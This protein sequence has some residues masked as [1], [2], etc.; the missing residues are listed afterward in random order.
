MPAIVVTSLL[1]AGLHA[2][3]WPAPIGIF[4]LSMALGVVY[5]RTGSLL[6]AMVMHG[7]F[8]G[9]STILFLIGTLARS[10]QEPELGPE[11]VPRLEP[12][13]RAVVDLFSRI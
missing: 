11:V 9:C 8:N 2:P 4:F 5:Q 13:I 12:A 6:T 3:Q 10:L 1:F 7:V